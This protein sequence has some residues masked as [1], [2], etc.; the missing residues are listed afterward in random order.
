MK[1]PNTNTLVSPAVV[2]TDSTSTAPVVPGGFTLGLDLGDRRHFVCALDAAGNVSHEGFLAN[3]R[4]ALLKLLE[5]FPRATVAL[6]AGTHSPWIS[7]FLTEQGAK[8]IVANP[9]KLHAISRHERK[10]DQRDAQMLARLARVDAALLHPI[11]HGSAQAQHDLLGLKL[12]DALVRSRVSLINA[13]RF[14]LK[15]LGH[16]VRNPSSESFHKT[17]LKEIPAASQPVVQPLLG[18]LEHITAQIKNLERQLV[19]RSKRDYPVTQRLQ[20]IAGVGPLTALCFV[21]KIGDPHRFGRSRDVGA[22]LGLCPRRDQSGGT[23]KQLRIT[24]CGDGLLRRLLVNAAHYVLGPFGPACAL[25]AHGERLTGSGS[26]REK[27]RA[28]VAVARKLAVLLL[29]LWKHGQDYEL[30]TSALPPGPAPA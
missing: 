12:R 5:Q 11:A 21:L 22:Y 7:R 27:K 19:Q 24:K 26:M 17:V 18:V 16:T 13:V 2:P 3:S 28:V 15:S 1:K 8:V 10:C 23:E 4:P 20:Q 29:S 6:E 30:R 9:R 14:T 25:R